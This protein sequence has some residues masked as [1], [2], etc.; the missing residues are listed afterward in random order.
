VLIVEQ[1]ALAALE[2]SDRVYVMD[3]GRI[4]HE[5]PAQELR[6]NEPLRRKLIGM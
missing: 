4:I 3:R 1:N 2:V 6:E 5:G